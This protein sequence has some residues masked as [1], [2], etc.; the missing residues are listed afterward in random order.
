M[1]S[2]TCENDWEKACGNLGCLLVVY[3]G[4]RFL[5]NNYLGVQEDLACVA[6][7]GEEVTTH[8]SVSA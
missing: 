2:R 4:R 6:G 3:L 7:T 5:M 8:E 1:F